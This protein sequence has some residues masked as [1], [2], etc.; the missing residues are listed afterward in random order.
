MR[1]YLTSMA[2]DILQ[3]SDR[4][5][6]VALGA[7]ANALFGATFATTVIGAVGA[8]GSASTGASIAGLAGAAKSTA[9]FYWIGG[10]VG[11]GV[12]AGTAVVGV[13]AVGVGIWGSMKARKAVL[14]TSRDKALS[15][16]EQR[17]IL[18][19]GNLVQAIEKAVKA[20][21]PSQREVGLF[22]KIGLQPLLSEIEAGLASGAFDEMK[23][24]RRVRLRG[25]VNNLSRYIKRQVHAD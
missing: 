22:V 1:L 13:G 21:T 23:V 10:L 5:A 20:G 7:S 15:D 4:R 6:R 18:A 9:T 14:G 8:L 2:A 25:R 3:I 12:A 11:G 17:I 19:I 24:Y 16:V